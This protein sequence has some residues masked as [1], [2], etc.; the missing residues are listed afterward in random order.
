[1]FARSFSWPV[2][3]GSQLAILVGRL[4]LQI[5]YQE[6]T[7]AE[8]AL[9]RSPKYFCNPSCHGL[10]VFRLWLFKARFSSTEYL[11]RGTFIGNSF[12]PATCNFTLVSVKA[13][14]SRANSYHEQLPSGVA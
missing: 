13:N 2:S 12:G 3:T 1:M 5:C 9:M 14:I 4:R 8:T 10:N 6:L 7:L 11:G